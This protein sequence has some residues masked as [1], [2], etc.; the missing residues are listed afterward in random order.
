MT[1]YIL[2]QNKK[3]GRRQG[4][5]KKVSPEIQKRLSE[6]FFLH[7]DNKN[8]EVIPDE[9]FIFCGI[10]PFRENSVARKHIS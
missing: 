7:A 9:V 2:V 8:S 4:S 6:A 10:V 5:K 3:R 1:V